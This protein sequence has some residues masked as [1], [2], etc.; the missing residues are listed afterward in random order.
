MIDFACKK[1]GVDGVVKCGLGL[2]R[3]E[4]RVMKYFL[5]KGCLGCTSIFVADELKLNL[6]TIQKAVKKLSEKGV[7]VRHQRNL[8][9]GGYVYVY[10]CVSRE[11][12]RGIVKEIIRKWAREVEKHIDGW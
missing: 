11:K 12:V 10:E 7:I 4:F 8:E 9:N 3:A 1:F 6:T 2:S 5:K